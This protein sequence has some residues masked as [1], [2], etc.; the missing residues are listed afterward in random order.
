MKIILTG[1][2][3]T[4]KTTLIRRL[5]EL[6]PDYAVVPEIARQLA[7]EG[8]TINERATDKDQDA[9]FNRLKTELSKKD[10]MFSDRG[11]IDVIA[12]DYYLMNQGRLSEDTLNKHIVEFIDFMEENDDVVYIFVPI[13]F[14]VEE[15]GVRST[16]EDFRT[17]IESSIAEILGSEDFGGAW[18]AVS[19]TVG[20][21]IVQIEEYL[22]GLEQFK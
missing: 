5:S 6:H 4:G 2:Q 18:F 13:E 21:R 1:A 16:D 19:G 12:Y 20:E 22:A 8:Y 11:L 10:D 3:G 7:K 14:P 15:D 17:Q 9:I